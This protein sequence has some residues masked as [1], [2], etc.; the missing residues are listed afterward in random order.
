MHEGV[1]KEENIKEL[2][3]S[4]GTLY[5]KSGHADCTRHSYVHACMGQKDYH[6]P[7]KPT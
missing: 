1:Q 5:K 6:V 2:R 4:S 7:I 3:T